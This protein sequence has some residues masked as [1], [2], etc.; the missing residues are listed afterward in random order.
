MAKSL[1]DYCMERDVFELL[2]Q[3]D[4]DENGSL[5]PRDVSHGSHKKI[6]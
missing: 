4:K 6:W 5:T 3:W 2:V 1:Y